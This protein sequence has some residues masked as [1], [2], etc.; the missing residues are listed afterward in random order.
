MDTAARTYLTSSQADRVD[1]ILA[2][3]NR[4]LVEVGVDKITMRQLAAESQVAAATLYNRFGS[5]DNIITLAVIDH[6][7]RS[8]QTIV[9]QVRDVGSPLDHAVYSLKV[10]HA[11]A[12]REPAFPRALMKTYFKLESDRSM[13]ERLYQ[14]LYQTWLPIVTAMSDSKSLRPW[15]DVASLCTELCDCEMNVMGQWGLGIIP[16]D[17]LLDKLTFAVLAILL[18]AST[19]A[20]AEAVAKLM[21][22]RLANLKKLRSGASAAKA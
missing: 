12:M 1:R 18:G 14:A 6:F 8:I 19:G 2:A 13:P 16:D 3:T 21:Q 9:S 7:E 22:D 17:Q 4:L 11:E 20:Q 15:F 5:K 10:V